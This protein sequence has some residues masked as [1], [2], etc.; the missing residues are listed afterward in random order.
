[1]FAFAVL[2]L[3]TSVSRLM[4]LDMQIISDTQRGCVPLPVRLQAE[5]SGGSGFYHCVWDFDDADGIQVDKIGK[6]V[7]WLY[8]FAG[9]YTITLAVTDSDGL[10]GKASLSVQVDSSSY[11]SH[12]AIELIGQH[13]KTPHIIEGYSISHTSG[14]AINIIHCSNVIIRNNYI[15]HCDSSKTAGGPNQNGTAIYVQD[16]RQIRVEGNIL[17]DNLRGMNICATPKRYS[18]SVYPNP[19]SLTSELPLT[20]TNIPEDAIVTLYDTLGRVVAKLKPEQKA[21]SNS[22]FFAGFRLCR[23]HPASIFIKFI[24]QSENLYC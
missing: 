19:Y 8:G 12:P 23:L 1:M 13:F 15:V 21:G 10:F 6:S 22:L 5:V 3:L 16:S 9:S 7:T 20:F 14:N 11:Q 17:L 24:T 2:L 18:I 4:G